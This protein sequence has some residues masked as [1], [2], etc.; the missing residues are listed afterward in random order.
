[1]VSLVPILKDWDWPKAL[2]MTHLSVNGNV[3]KDEKEERDD[4]VDN[5]VRVDEVDLGI[6]D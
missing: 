3:K 1:M 4:P 6:K 2:L 5:Q